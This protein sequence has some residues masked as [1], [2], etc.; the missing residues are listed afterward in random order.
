MM[1]SHY[2][3]TLG[4]PSEQVQITPRELEE[5]LEFLKDV[6]VDEFGVVSGL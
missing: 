6:T 5:P 3:N 1:R 4:K 2:K